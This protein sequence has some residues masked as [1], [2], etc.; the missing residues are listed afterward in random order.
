M[1]KR[2]YVNHFRCLQNFSLPIGDLSTALLIGKNGAGKS[3]VGQ[4]FKI[5]Q[6]IGRGINRVGKLVTPQDLSFGNQALPI[7]LEIEAQLAE[8]TYAYTLALELPPGFKE[9]RV[10]EESLT[11]DQ[12][13]R[14][15]REVAE[16]RF[17]R[18]SQRSEGTMSVDWHLVGL[19]VLQARSEQDPVHIFQQW[20]ARMLILS[21]IPS[22]IDG[23]SSGE[24][25]NPNQEVT[26][27]GD[28]WTG[29]L[30]HSPS[31]YTRIDAHLRA[32]L[33]DLK[34][35]KNP[36]IARDARSLIVQFASTSGSETMPF[37]FLSDGE[38]CMFIW[39]LTL[40]ANEA[41]G[42]LF[43]FWDEPDNYLAHSEVSAFTMDLRRAFQSGG[44]FV[45][46]SHNPAAIQ[47]FSDE[48]T[49]ILHRRNHLEPT[50][51]LKL[52]EATDTDLNDVL[53]QVESQP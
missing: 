40:A 32:L 36:L 21:P 48:N 41:Y 53:E 33:P 10:V 5:L 45:A 8:K 28:W 42:P 3:T 9:L 4:A 35:V 20:L 31:A 34:D 13:V 14:F 23:D 51:L 37:A 6:K 30:N 12:Q 15:K 50:Q 16:L 2:F 39:A 19:T 46:T 44:Q 26:N 22:L 49:L 18:E 29:L 17:P 25:L 47:R 11:V 1:I 38:K 24:T 43:C 52:S 27:L 7:R